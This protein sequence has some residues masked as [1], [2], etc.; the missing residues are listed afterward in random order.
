MNIFNLW[1]IEKQKLNNQNLPNVFINQRE[2]WFAKLGKNVGFEQDGK[3]EFNRPILVI[4]KIGNLFL[5]LPLTKSGKQNHLFYHLL[6]SIKYEKQ[7]N[8]NYSSF[9]ILSQ[10]KVLDKKRFEERMGIISTEEFQIIQK[11]LKDIIF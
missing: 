6:K 1:S 9:L 4:K 11:K 10:I 5:T 3:K 2:I 8:K 7:K